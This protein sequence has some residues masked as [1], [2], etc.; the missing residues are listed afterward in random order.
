M[1]KKGIKCLVFGILIFGSQSF[2]QIVKFKTS[3][4]S[5]TSKS[6]N[7]IWEKYTEP[8]PVVN[9]VALDNHKARL[10]MYSEV[11][12]FFEIL[13]YFDIEISDKNETASFAAKDQNG[14]GCI[15]SIITRKNQGNRKQLYIK[16]E[17]RILLFDIE[18]IN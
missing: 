14:D 16:Y 18:L 8:R 2:S 6:D 17:D 1:Y 15:I 10:I 7:G 4:I 13:K 5:I 9:I 3:S 11:V 12:Q